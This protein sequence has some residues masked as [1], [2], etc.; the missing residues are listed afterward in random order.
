MER[1]RGFNPEEEE[2]QPEPERFISMSLFRRFMSKAH[3]GR[4]GDSLYY[5]PSTGQLV[6]Y[7]G[8][9]KIDVSRSLD[10]LVPPEDEE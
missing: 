8:G 5:D 9:K 10:E 1:F 6:D 2:K 7:Q 3:G 4:E